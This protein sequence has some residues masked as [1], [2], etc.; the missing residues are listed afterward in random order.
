MSGVGSKNSTEGTLSSVRWLTR[1]ATAR[2][3]SGCGL[4][5]RAV[6]TRTATSRIDGTHTDRDSM[7]MTSS[8]APATWHRATNPDMLN[9]QAVTSAIW[10]CHEHVSPI[11]YRIAAVEWID[12][13]AVM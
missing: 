9:T 4:A 12:A 7:C 11:D 8:S 5:S 13:H 6:I 10:R 3:G 2:E 1:A